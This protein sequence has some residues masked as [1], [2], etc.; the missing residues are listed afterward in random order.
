MTGEENT[1]FQDLAL[2]IYDLCNDTG[3]QPPSPEESEKFIARLA[4]EMY[5]KFPIYKKQKE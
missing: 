2:I 3:D 5:K 1:L 4:D